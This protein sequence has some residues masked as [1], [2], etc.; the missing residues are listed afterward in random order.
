MAKRKSI[1]KQC[2]AFSGLFEVELLVELILR[3]W[4]HPLA[5]DAIFR[6]NLLEQAVEA[7]RLSISGKRLIQEIAPENMNYV[8][9]IWYVEWNALASGAEDPEGKRQSW[10]VALK[11]SI[12]SCFCDPDRLL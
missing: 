4:Q 6:N 9:A 1:A 8:A 3:H 2:L 12:P 11:H 5:A 7:I 10:L